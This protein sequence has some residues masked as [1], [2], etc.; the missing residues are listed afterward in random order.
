MKPQSERLLQPIG[1]SQSI[2]TSRHRAAPGAGRND[3][4]AR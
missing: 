3:S 2:R 1:P 4:L